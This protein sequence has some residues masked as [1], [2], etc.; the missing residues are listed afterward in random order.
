MNIKDE[1]RKC[2]GVDL[3]QQAL[4]EIERLERDL[5]EAQRMVLAAPYKAVLERIAVALEKRPLSHFEQI[6]GGKVR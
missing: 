6:F 2:V 1:L 5:L 3:C 4:A